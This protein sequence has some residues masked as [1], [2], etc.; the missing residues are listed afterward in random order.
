MLALSKNIETK[1]KGTVKSHV[2]A[3]YLKAGVGIIMGLFIVII[4]SS[5]R[6]GTSIFSNWWLA[7]WSDDESYRYR[8]LNNCT[9]IQNN[10]NTVWSMSNADWNNH[11]NQRFYIYCV[12]VFILVLIT[13]FRSMITEF[14]FLNA[15]RVLH[16]KMFRRLIR[17]PI[18]FFDIN[19]V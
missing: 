3:E 13:F 5:V 10:N 17:C 15:G 4:L 1:H 6:E 7:K 11:R 14:M 16:N 12:M 19:P 9:N 8:I 2:Y 18:A